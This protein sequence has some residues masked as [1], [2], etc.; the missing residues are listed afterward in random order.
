ML[1]SSDVGKKTGSMKSHFVY[2][3]SKL[4]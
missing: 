4:D 1:E 3:R 2:Q